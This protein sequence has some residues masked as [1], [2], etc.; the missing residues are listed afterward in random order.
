MRYH[1]S[2]PSRGKPPSI[3]HKDLAYGEHARHRLDVFVPSTKPLKAPIV[4][5]FHG[6]GYVSGERSPLPGLRSAWDES[7]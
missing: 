7:V 5:Y 2:L 6:S 4:V 1:R 3:R